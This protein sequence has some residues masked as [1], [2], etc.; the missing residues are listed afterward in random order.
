MINSESR[1][2]CFLVLIFVAMVFVIG[3]TYQVFVRWPE[4][5]RWS[6][7]KLR[8]SL[9]QSPR[10]YIPYMFSSSEKDRVEAGTTTNVILGSSMLMT[11]MKSYNSD[12][13]HQ[14]LALHQGSL[15][16]VFMYLRLDEILS[17][18]PK[19][20]KILLPIS[21]LRTPAAKNSIAIT[22]DVP[23]ERFLKFFNRMQELKKAHQNPALEEKIGYILESLYSAFLFRETLDSYKPS[24]IFDSTIEEIFFN[25][26]KKPRSQILNSNND[27]SATYFNSNEEEL[28]INLAAFDLV[29]EELEKKSIQFY[30]IEDQGMQA[31]NKYEDSQNREFFLERIKNYT[32]RRQNF[33]FIN[34]EEVPKIADEH[35]LDCLHVPPEKLDWKQEKI[36]YLIGI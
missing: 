19:K 13:R 15:S 16:P 17:L 36:N 8:R 26:A 21:L 34:R 18:S 1:R 35:Y 20:I 24:I 11:L 28:E 6:T 9:G 10:A 22:S 5:S 7:E 14:A 30:F 31:C 29:A 3:H 33:K 12:L 23:R 25:L 27:R 32:A 4:F 2:Y